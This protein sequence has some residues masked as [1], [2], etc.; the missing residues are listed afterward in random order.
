V[1]VELAAPDAQGFAGAE[2]DAVVAHGLD[3][4]ALGI[5]VGPN[6]GGLFGGGG[7]EGGGTGGAAVALVRHV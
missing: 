5:G 6:V 1:A 2:V 7:L 3:G 4:L